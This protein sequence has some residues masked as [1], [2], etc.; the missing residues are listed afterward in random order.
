VKLIIC[1]M[2]FESSTINIFAI[3]SLAAVTSKFFAK[4]L[5][6]LSFVSG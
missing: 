4:A 6:A 3:G 5:L 2:E 1:R